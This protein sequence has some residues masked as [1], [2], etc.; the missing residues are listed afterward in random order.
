MDHWHFPSRCAINCRFKSQNIYTRRCKTVTKHVHAFEC[1]RERWTCIATPF[2][3]RCDRIFVSVTHI[4]FTLTPFDRSPLMWWRNFFASF[5]SLVL[6]CKFIHFLLSSH[7]KMRKNFSLTLG[8][9][10]MRLFLSCYNIGMRRK[11]E[12]FLFKLLK[13]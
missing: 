1:D 2:M 4:A 6:S 12:N 13:I 7:A 5:T 8:R 9:E 11:W 3:M 10:F